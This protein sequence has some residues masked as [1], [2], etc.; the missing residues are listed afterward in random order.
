MNETGAVEQAIKRLMDALDTLDSAIELRVEDDHGSLTEQVHAFSADRARLASELDSAR[1]RS[2]ELEAV[3][4]EAAS[5]LDDAMN[6]IRSVIAAS[7]R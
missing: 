4:R 1:A 7:D 3:N 5:R 2:R 6:A